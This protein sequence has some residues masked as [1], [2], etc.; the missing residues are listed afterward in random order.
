MAK[1]FYEQGDYDRAISLYEDLYSYRVIEQK[2]TDASTFFH[3]NTLITILLNEANYDR[4]K[5]V[6][7]TAF[8]ALPEVQ[9]IIANLAGYSRSDRW[10]VEY[11]NSVSSR[12]DAT[13]SAVLYSLTGLEDALLKTPDYR[14]AYHLEQFKVMAGLAVVESHNEESVM[15][16]LMECLNSL[17]GGVDK[18]QVSKFIFNIISTTILLKPYS[19]FL[20]CRLWKTGRSSFRWR[21]DPRAAPF[22]RIW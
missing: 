17:C 13:H 9:S 21:T 14:F 8:G 11:H 22:T 6:I 18:Y 15:A 3:M 2:N 7:T 12:L 20:I 10:L 16:M 4:I 5:E 19:A 1:F